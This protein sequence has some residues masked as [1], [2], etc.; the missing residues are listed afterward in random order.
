VLTTMVVAVVV[1]AAGYFVGGMVGDFSFKRT[2]RGRLLVSTVGVILGALLMLITL[3]IPAE[4]QDLFLAMLS[5]NALFVPFFVP[6]VTSTVYDITLPEV[7]T[8]AMAAQSFVTSVGAALAPFLAGL[9]AV[10]SSLKDAILITCVSAWVICAV[11]LTV[12]T[13]LV[14]GDIQALRGQLRQRAERERA[15]QGTQDV[16]G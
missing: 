7:R 11:F 6:N 9:I 13:Y 15:I 4:N 2:P 3:N 8:T 10:R 16:A 14:P 5:L 1:L 12:A